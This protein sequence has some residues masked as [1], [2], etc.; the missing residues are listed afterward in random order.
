MRKAQLAATFR[1]A[2][3]RPGLVW[4]FAGHRFKRTALTVRAAQVRAA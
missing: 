1:A 2:S 3:P 4:S